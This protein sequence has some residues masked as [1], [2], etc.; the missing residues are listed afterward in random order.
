MEDNDGKR[1]INKEFIPILLLLATPALAYMNG[2]GIKT[3]SVGVDIYYIAA[4]VFGVIM[5][6]KENIPVSYRYECILLIMLEIVVNIPYMKSDNYFNGNYTYLF[7]S[8]GLIIMFFLASGVSFF[9]NRPYFID[10]YKTDKSQYL[11]MYR[12]ISVFFL[13]VIVFHAYL[14]TKVIEILKMTYK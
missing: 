12:I 4:M 10:Y 9:I 3:A 2:F 1:G 5:S 7:I 6:V 8:Y 14:F 13:G 11:V